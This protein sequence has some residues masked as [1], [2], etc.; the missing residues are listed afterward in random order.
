MNEA[1]LKYQKLST[2]AYGLERGTPQS[3]GL[4]VFSPIDFKIK[5]RSDILVPLD[6]RLDIPEGWDVSVYNKSGVATKKKLF[7]G[8]ELIDS[9]YYGNIH[10]HLFNHS[11]KTVKFKKGDKIAQIVMRPVWLGD[12]NEVDFIDP[13]GERGEGGFGSTGDKKND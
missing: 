1:T 2:N 10:V 11:N 6:I 5:R 9:D 3:S 4:D 12:P 8:A 13:V 7:K